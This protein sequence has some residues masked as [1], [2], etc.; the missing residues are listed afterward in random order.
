MDASKLRQTDQHK[1]LRKWAKLI[2]TFRK[3]RPSYSHH[4]LASMIEQGIV[5][6][7]LS[8]NVDNLLSIAGVDTALFSSDAGNKRCVEIHGCALQSK[9]R[10]CSRITQTN[11]EILLQFHDGFPAPCPVC[12]DPEGGLWPAIL[13]YNEHNTHSEAMLKF[14]KHHIGKPSVVVFLGTSVRNDAKKIIKN[15]APNSITVRIDKLPPN[16]EQKKLF[17]YHMVCEIDDLMKMLLTRLSISLPNS[18]TRQTPSHQSVMNTIICNLE[19]TKSAS[20]EHRIA[21]YLSKVQI[22]SDLI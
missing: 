19:A 15:W 16:S 18:I 3:S 6:F 22:Y 9:C 20:S 5:S 10:K 7:L 8:L 17:D 21:K 1:Y 12:R 14:E 13:H 4:A 11:D 2:S